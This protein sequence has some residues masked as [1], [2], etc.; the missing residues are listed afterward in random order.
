MSQAQCALLVPV[1]R[2]WWSSRESG[3]VPLTKDEAE[4]YAGALG[5]DVAGL[6]AAADCGRCHGEPGEWTS[7]LACGAKGE[8]TG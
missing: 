1:P 8:R 3:E 5:T 4:A 2:P 6:M 7:C